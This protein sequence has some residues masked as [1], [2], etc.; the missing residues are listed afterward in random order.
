MGHAMRGSLLRVCAVLLLVAAQAG[1]GGMALAAEPEPK[2]AFTVSDPRISEASGLAVSRQ[3]PGIVYTHNDSD[4]APTIFAVGSNG[5]TRATYTVTGAQARDWEGMALGRDGAGRPALFLADMGD[6]LGGA[7]PYI[8][9]Y[10]V[11]EPRELRDQTLRATPFRLKYADGARDAESVLIDPR[12]NRLY[13]ASKMLN[14]ALYAA[15]ARLKP[16]G[17]N[18]L[19]K[20][21]DAPAIATDGAFAPDGRSFVIRTYGAAHIYAMTAGGRPGKRLDAITLPDQ[22]QGESIAYTLDGRSLLAGSEGVRQ[23]MWR[24]PVPD[25][26]RPSATAT[27]SRSPAATG[28]RPDRKNG[29]TVLGLV[30]AAGAA[31]VVAVV[32]VRRRS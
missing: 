32:V 20:V 22:E 29:G 13:I 30:L 27:A 17:F 24:V 5:R 6:N 25:D 23:P 1:T 8:T 16:T 7:W 4:G 14:S 3:H 9:V 31:M 26:A 12:T 28:E 19:R 11:P 18:V 15:P 10:R 21:G 2:V